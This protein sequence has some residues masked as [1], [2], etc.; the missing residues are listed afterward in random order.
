VPKNY[1]DS[2]SSPVMGSFQSRNAGVRLTRIFHPCLLRRPKSFHG[3]AGVSL[4]DPQRVELS[5]YRPLRRCF[6]NLL[7]YGKPA[8]P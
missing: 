2:S 3:C 6:S 1:G 8:D 4:R 7:G 5:G